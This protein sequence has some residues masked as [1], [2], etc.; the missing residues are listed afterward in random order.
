M[1]GIRILLLLAASLALLSNRLPA[2]HLTWQAGY[3]G[4]LDNR[5]Y[6]NPYVNDQTIFGARLSG[7]LGFMLND[8]NRIAA[9]V[10][11]LYEFGSKGEGQPPDPVL[12]YNNTR[13]HTDFYIGA[14]PRL[15]LVEMPMALM[16]D[17][18]R[19]FRPNVE[20]IFFRYHTGALMQNVWI[21]W[22]GR[23]SW[24][25]RESF[26]LGF[27]GTLHKGIFIWQHHFVM[28]HLAHSLQPEPDIHLRDNGGYSAMV[29]LDLSR[30][31]GLDTLTLCTGILGSYDRIRSMYDLRFPVG[32]IA[33][34]EAVYRGFGLH[35]VIYS[36]DNQTI[37]SGDG[38]Y[39]SSFYSRVDGFYELNRK[40]LTGRIQ[41]SAHM[42]PGILDLSM[43]LLVRVSIGGKRKIHQ[44][45]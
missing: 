38:F 24:Q 45:S 32:W 1:K 16:T 13:R 20:G 34:A 9:G 41:F 29:G 31:T 8:S 3:F 42:V 4:F 37:V 7:A 44:S 33:E 23:P 10:D 11:Y 19:Y 18:F 43:S 6:F 17:T 22:T 14:F 36:G 35:G 26:M 40:E 5:E 2:Q 30:L 28:S 12:Y 39:K 21:D 15:G 25:R 27:S